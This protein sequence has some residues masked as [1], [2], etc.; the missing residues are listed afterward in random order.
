MEENRK[1]N[2][3][4]MSTPA[5]RITSTSQPAIWDRSSSFALGT[6]GTPSALDRSNLRPLTQTYKGAQA[7]YEVLEYYHVWCPKILTQPLLCLST[8]KVNQQRATPQPNSSL[9][10]K[11][12]DFVFGW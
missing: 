5:M 6:S 1:E 7:D 2:M 11:A 12:M 8:L 10:S 3:P 4:G 9:V